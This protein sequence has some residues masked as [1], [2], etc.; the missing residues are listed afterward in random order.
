MILSNQ[1]PNSAA[2]S[3]M[4]PQ[5]FWSLNEIVRYQE[6][7]QMKNPTEIRAESKGTGMKVLK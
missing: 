4:N 6:G 7:I 2:K 1:A 3:I 5:F